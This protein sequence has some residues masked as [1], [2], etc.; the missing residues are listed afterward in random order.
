M[1]QRHLYTVV[2]LTTTVVGIPSVGRAETNKK[3]VTAIPSAS[4]SEVAKVGEYQS[5][6]AN[7]TSDASSTRIYSYNLAGNQ[8]A[9]L[10][11]RDIPVLTF[12][13]SSPDQSQ[14]TKIGETGNTDTTKASK[15]GSIADSNNQVSNGDNDAVERASV[16]AAKIND[17]I[18]SKIDAS[19]ITVSWQ[20][21][22]ASTKSENSEQALNDR[23]IIK[24]NG[25][26]LVEIDDNTRLPDTTKNLA[27]D[28]LQATN[29]LRRLIGNASPISSIANLPVRSPI[30]IPKIS[31]STKLPHLPQ[32]IALGPVRMTI[33]GW[34]SF[35]GYDGSGDY[36]ATGE[37]YNPEGL[38]A[39]HRTL[40]LGTRI[41]V[42]N[43]NNGRSVVVRVNDRG[44]YVRGRVLDLSVGA[45]RIL[46]MMSSGVA[47]V[48][49]EVLGH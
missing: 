49:I 14:K 26:P 48:K 29:R 24:A 8:A 13:S 20:R 18:R 33:K 17:L 42:T 9:T 4:S 39:A 27:Q 22:T 45:A 36:T 7:L 32:Q 12:V 38:T 23:Y 3:T 16:V 40:P 44:P 25:S 31:I 30:A 35:Y 11:V 15:L 10:Y 2:A 5:P 34:A 41:R 46:G 21:G 37:R 6:A 28:A 19:K 47:P 1:N 43:T